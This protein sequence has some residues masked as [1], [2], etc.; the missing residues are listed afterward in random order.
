MAAP[1]SLKEQQKRYLQ[2]NG[3]PVYMSARTGYLTSPQIKTSA[4]ISAFAAAAIL[5]QG[6]AA[7]AITFAAGMIG[8]TAIDLLAHKT[9]RH[10][11]RL[12]F[13]G[14]AETSC[15]DTAPDSKTPPTSP[16]HRL[17][18]R[19]MLDT[20]RLRSAVSVAFSPVF[21]DE[22]YRVGQFITGNADTLSN[23]DLGFTCLFLANAIQ[24]FRGYYRHSQIDR[25]KWVITDMPKKIAQEQDEKA[26]APVPQMT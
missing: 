22:I 9:I 21:G 23:A 25:E 14:A 16:E 13:K 15:I 18:N 12:V 24:S 4:L 8:H 20:F 26:H 2:L 10:H 11:L 19:I 7:A 17:H 1:R 3:D 5:P 6:A